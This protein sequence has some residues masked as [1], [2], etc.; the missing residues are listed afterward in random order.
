MGRVANRGSSMAVDGKPLWAGRTTACVVCAAE[1][2]PIDSEAENQPYRGTVFTSHGHYGS[3]AF[4]PLDGTYLEL[5]VCDRCL[6]AAAANGQ[7]LWGRDRELVIEEGLVVGLAPLDEP[8]QL[9]LWDPEQE[10]H[11]QAKPPAAAREPDQAGQSLSR[12]RGPT[13]EARR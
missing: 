11:P 8:C 12:G 9:L 13:R 5:T 4:D 1:L 2:E 10:A 3:T 7:V 6:L